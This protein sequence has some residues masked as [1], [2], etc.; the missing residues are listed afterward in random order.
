MWSNGQTTSSA[1]NLAAGI[2]TVAVTDG[3]LCTKVGSWQVTQ[4]SALSGNGVVTNVTCFGGNN[5]TATITGFGG[6]ASYTYK[7]ST[8]STAQLIT[9]L[10][11][12]TYTVTITDANN[13][14]NIT[15]QTITQP[16]EII[17]AGTTTNVTCQG[18]NTGKITTTVTGGT[19]G[20]ISYQWN[21]GQTGSTASS[22][23][24]GTYTVTVTNIAGCTKSRSFT[25]TENSA[26]VFGNVAVS[27]PTCYNSSNG[28]I[29]LFVSGGV[30]PY[31]YLWS[32]G[33]T[34]SAAINLAAGIYTV[35]VTDGGPC[36]KV[37]YWVVTQPSAVSGNGAVTN[38]TCYGGNN[39]TATITGS[40]GTAP[41]NYKWTTN[42]TSQ[43]ITGLTAGAYYVTITDASSCQNVTVQTI[44]QPSDITITGTPVKVACQGGNN[45]QITTTVTGGSGGTLSYL[46]NNS[47]TAATAI[48]LAAGTYTVTVTNSSG[49]TKS[50][51]FAVT[52]NS[53]IAFG[54]VA[55][56]SPT[57][58]N[59]SNG[60]IQLFVSG[61]ALPYS[62][63]WN[64][65]QTTGTLINLSA[66][67]YTVTVTDA[68]PCTKVGSWQLTQPAAIA[69]T[70]APVNVTCPGS[71]NGLITT[72]VT[73]GSGGT[74][75]YLWNNGQTGSTA[76]SLTAGTYTVTVTNGAG[77]VASSLPIIV[78]TAGVLPGAAGLITGPAVVNQGQTGV[79]YSVAP[80][81][82]ATGYIWTLPTGAAIASGANTAY[83]T[84]NFSTTA[85]SGII[86]VK[87]TNECGSGTPSGDKSIAVIQVSLV[88]QNISLGTGTYCYSATQTIYVAGGSTTFVVNSGALVTMIAGQN[89][90][91]QPGTTVKYGGYM[92]GYITTNGQ[93]C[94]T[95]SNPVVNNTV[96]GDE[97]QMP[98]PEIVN[99][100]HIRAYPN[101]TNGSFTLELTGIT[102]S[103]MTKVEICGMNGIKVIS[104][105]LAG[106]R[107]H[108]FSVESLRPGI[109]FIHVTTG[110]SN[111]TMKLIKL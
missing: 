78:G 99:N 4:P 84:V 32:N 44:T 91:Y 19:A 22:L 12:G 9:G 15:F 75:T 61:G 11:A 107:K 10:A 21:N 71:S 37:G 45:G 41:Y 29:Q 7:W 40:G 93:Y 60:S 31:A 73:G 64:N 109:Y 13:C 57:C 2:Y 110:T 17:I 87:G 50:K 66:G 33:Q 62:Y 82:N 81:A 47:Q 56:I 14:A 97:V 43:L 51:S 20:T 67:I 28:S 100:Q 68:G 72:I 89:I 36:T 24:A 25:V 52:E 104:E 98:V 54:N 27:S 35:T 69:I 58:Y 39:G 46:W 79:A 105:D 34:T 74:T 94:T 85:S 3:G 63:L 90:I 18:G 101:P 77:C 53:A 1:I 42:S 48:N 95:P 86:N 76:T 8:G 6:T 16:S 26:I 55:V 96:Q 70:G 49:C 5:G 92:H 80:I 83:I 103:G 88:L 30:L 102:E 38:V 108:A 65:G 23:A 59:G 111:E 106:E